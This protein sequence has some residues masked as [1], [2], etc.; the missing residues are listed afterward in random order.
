[1]KLRSV[2]Q[3]KEAGDEEQSDMRK[4][5]AMRNKVCDARA[6]RNK[7]CDLARAMSANRNMKLGGAYFEC[8]N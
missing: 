7:V 4:K 5:S 2:R 6:M 1:M 8:L 3:E